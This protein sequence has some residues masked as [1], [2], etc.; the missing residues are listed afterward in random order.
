MK[1]PWSHP[2]LAAPLSENACTYQGE[3]DSSTPPFLPSRTSHPGVPASKVVGQK[4][5]P[6]LSCLE[7]ERQGTVV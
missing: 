2:W 3:E 4:R 1:E 5:T 7:K 6:P